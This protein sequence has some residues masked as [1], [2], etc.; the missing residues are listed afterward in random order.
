[1][2]SFIPPRDMCNVTT[3]VSGR[4]TA[5]ARACVAEGSSLTASSEE[6]EAGAC[7]NPPTLTGS[8]LTMPSI[9]SLLSP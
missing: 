2:I 3:I 6:S 7:P 5:A 1:M 9:N 8:L 4:S